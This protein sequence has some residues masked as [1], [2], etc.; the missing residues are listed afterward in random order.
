MADQ[1]E[2]SRDVAFTGA[3][4][5]TLAGGDR[6]PRRESKLSELGVLDRGWML[7]RRGRI[8]D[9]GEGDAPGFGP[10]VD[11]VHAD[12]RVV[13]PALVDCH[14]H[15]CSAGDRSDEFEARLAGADYLEILAAGGGIMSTVRSIRKAPEELLVDS[16]LGR[17]RR[18]ARLGTGTVEVKS[19]YGLDPESELKMLRAITAAAERGEIAA[20][21]LRSYHDLLAELQMASEN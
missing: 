13:M 15:A 17:L 4:L 20:S 7:V 5:V 9:M 14:T 18:M 10:S 19:G 2:P 21:R 8:A 3:R 16:L 1:T 12:G 11:I 6:E